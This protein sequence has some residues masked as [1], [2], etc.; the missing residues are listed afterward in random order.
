[1]LYRSGIYR[2]PDSARVFF[3]RL[4]PAGDVVGGGEDHF[5][6]RA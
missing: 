3:S 6:L 2:M 1:M 5:P 4:H